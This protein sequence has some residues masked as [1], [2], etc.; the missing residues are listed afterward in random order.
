MLFFVFVCNGLFTLDKEDNS[1]KISVKLHLRGALKDIVYSYFSKELKDINDVIIKDEN[2]DLVLE[3]IT[4]EPELE[5]GQKSGQFIIFTVIFDNFYK[6][7][8]YAIASEAK[9]TSN[10]DLFPEA[11]NNQV[12]LV[13]CISLLTEYKGVWIQVEDKKNLKTICEQFIKEFNSKFIED[14]RQQR[15]LALKDMKT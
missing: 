12:L 9:F 7:G 4:I 1:Q 15:N 14:W 11:N 6:K 8:A 3:V 2:P 13:N 10:E 5:K